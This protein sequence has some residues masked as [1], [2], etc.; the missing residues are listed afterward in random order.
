MEHGVLIGLLNLLVEIPGIVGCWFILTDFN[1][2]WFKNALIF[3][4]ELH[5]NDENWYVSAHVV[6]SQICWYWNR[7]KEH[8][9]IWKIM[10]NY[11][12]ALW[13]NCRNETTGLF[14][15]LAQQGQLHLYEQSAAIQIFAMLEWKVED[16]GKLAWAQPRFFCCCI[17]WKLN[18]KDIALLESAASAV[19][20]TLVMK[21]LGGG[22]FFLQFSNYFLS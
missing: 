6:I 4:G 12:D 10:K 16:Y 2:I 20:N 3:E 22:P 9:L 19:C 8:S 21:L 18:L 14:M 15:C 17:L 11:A 1:A 7:E 5:R 13:N